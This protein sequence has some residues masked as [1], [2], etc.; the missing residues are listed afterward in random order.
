[1]NLFRNLRLATRLGAVFG[2]VAAGLLSLDVVGVSSLKSEYATAERLGHKDMP[3][4]KALGSIQFAMVA[5][6]AD[7]LAHAHQTDDAGRAD[8]EAQ[9]AEHDA[10]MQKAFET[11]DGLYVNEHDRRLAASAKRYW[12][13]YKWIA[14]AER[15]R[16]ANVAE[17]KTTYT[18]ARTV[19]IV[20]AV[21]LTVLA[22]AA[23]VGVTRSVTRPVQRLR[24]RA[25]LESL[26]GAS[27]PRPAAT[28]RAACRPSRSP[29]RSRAATSS[30]SCRTSST[31]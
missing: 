6:R 18:S 7:Q 30:A 4:V 14:F 10:I 26:A 22:A 29:S 19:L 25:D 13:A 17:A 23:V 9:M 20:L 21:V 15:R 5:Y 2:T 31:R 28:S 12:E 11:Y 1:M 16:A 3:A 8:Q 27:T 24:A